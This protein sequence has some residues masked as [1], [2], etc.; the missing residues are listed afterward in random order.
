VRLERMLQALTKKK[1]MINSI[2]DRRHISLTFLCCSL[3]SKGTTISL[4]LEQENMHKI[5]LETAILIFSLLS[6]HFQTMSTDHT[7]DAALQCLLS[8]G[9][10]EVQRMPNKTGVLQ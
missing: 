4:H 7:I 10:L 1:M 5:T 3:N 2:S 9:T 8:F 6:I